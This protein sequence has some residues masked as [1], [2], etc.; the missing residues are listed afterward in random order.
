MF[1]KMPCPLCGKSLRVREESV[2]RKARCPHCSGTIEVQRPESLFDPLAAPAVVAP[3]QP[4]AAETPSTP[5]AAAPVT[6]P[7]IA[8][9][10]APSIRAGGSDSDGTSA[11]LLWTGLWAIGITALLYGLIAL[12]Y[13]PDHPGTVVGYIRA[14]FCERGPEQAATVLLTC[15]AFAILFV[16]YKKLSRQRD[17]LLFDVLP[18]EVSETIRPDNVDQFHKQI[19]WIPC[20]PKQSFLINRV[21]RALHHF[22][23]RG[24]VQEVA[25]QL[26]SQSEI[27]ATAVA[28]SYTMLKVFIWAIP[29]IGFIGTVRGI[30]MAV[31]N[32]SGS[33]GEMTEIDTLKNSLGGITSGLA[34]AFDTTFLALIMSMFIM[35]PMNWLQKGEEDLLNSIAEY[36]NEN[37]LRRMD[38]AKPAEQTGAEVIRAAIAA[39]MADHEAESQSWTKR[40][41]SIGSTVTHQVVEGWEGIHRQMQDGQRR[42]LQQMHDVLKAASEER[43]AFV[44][45]VKAVQ[46][47]Q[48]QELNKAVTSIA[49][50]AAQVQQQITSAQE[51]QARGF[52]DVVAALSGD[53]R[54]LQQAAR[55]QHEAE[56]GVLRDGAERLA[57]SLAEVA[58]RVGTLQSEF[59][60]SLENLGPATVNELRQVSAETCSAVQ[61]QVKTLTGVTELVDACSRSL[62]AQLEEL[63]ASHVTA[64]ERLSASL[65]EKLGSGLERSLATQTESAA[66]LSR[67]AASF[68]DQARAA[69]EEVQAARSAADS[70]ARRIGDQ[71]GAAAQATQ[72]LLSE[73]TNG[74]RMAS[75][76]IVAALGERAVTMLTHAQQQSD[77][78]AAERLAKFAQNESQL[79]EALRACEQRL[80]EQ[81]SSL[82]RAIEQGTALV[83]AQERLG[84]SLEKLLQSETLANTLPCINDRL[85]RL[86]PVLETLGRRRG[87]I[88]LGQPGSDGRPARR[89]W[90]LGDLFGGGSNNA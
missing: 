10:V 56:S 38:D 44:F 35:F 24:S 61:A 37:L 16:K 85:V 9:S 47:V 59:I 12:L 63:H 40:L 7:G 20:D 69:T 50:A 68:A 88:H 2:G 21:V 76:K 6:G 60:R 41:E 31:G 26:S 90:R 89:K 81:L 27:D 15:W 51:A 22:R 71:I 77:R 87:A 82:T 64:L 18:S 4:T 86:Q 78:A 79:S 25:S 66:Q 67:L 72:R 1:F 55:Q 39:A 80:A 23:S 46:D 33:V 62:A 32:F 17:S 52:K 11:N 74:L 8:P 36:T 75:E 13:I 54:A 53:L 29:I 58:S 49:G 5:Q 43:K 57:A 83:Q 14:L 84:M 34:T 19:G 3:Q 70:E 28:S 48:V 42:Q 30:G 73:S 45:Q 65:G